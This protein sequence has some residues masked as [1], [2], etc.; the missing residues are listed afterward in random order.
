MVRN[1]PR[2]RLLR[3]TAA[4]TTMHRG[5]TPTNLRSATLLPKSGIEAVAVDGLAPNQLAAT[6]GLSTELA[7]YRRKRLGLWR[8]PSV[9]GCP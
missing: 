1:S 3:H 7:K 5:T 9:R 8:E 2:F 6:C 4:S